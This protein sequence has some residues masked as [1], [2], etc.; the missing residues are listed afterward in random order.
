M[1]NLHLEHP[2][3]SSST[4]RE[5]FSTGHLATHTTETL[6]TN[7]ISAENDDDYHQ[8]KNPVQAI[9]NTKSSN[10]AKKSE[11]HTKELSKTA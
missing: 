9:R 11:R 4:A 2:A 3:T 7:P 6:K 8:N 1:E 5:I 10:D